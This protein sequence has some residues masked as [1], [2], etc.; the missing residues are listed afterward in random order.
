MSGI[1][2]TQKLASAL[3]AVSAGT[4]LEYMDQISGKKYS[5]NSSG[6]YFGV[7]YNASIATQGAGFS[8][9]TYLTNSDIIIPSF[10][11][12][13]GSQ[14]KWLVSMS[15]TA[16]S[17]ATPIYSLRFGTLRTTSDTARLAL[18]GPAQTAAADVGV[19]TIIVRVTSIGA[20][21]VIQGS[22]NIDHNGAATGFANNNASGVEATS[23]GFD[24]T[25]MN[26]GT[27]IGLSVNGGA[28]AS[29]T[30]TQVLTEAKW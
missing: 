16:A 21:G 5:K 1:Y 23:S 4:I 26:A 15:K 10:G 25:A 27:Y 6:R 29:W 11:L 12:Q 18:T 9:D 20:S 24:M 7:D 13:V 22:I 28:S 30:I 2:Y 3:P 17:T 19:L 8:S 14:F